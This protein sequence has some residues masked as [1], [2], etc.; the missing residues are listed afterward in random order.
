V[1]KKKAESSEPDNWKCVVAG[2]KKKIGADCSL[3]NL[4]EESSKLKQIEVI[5]LPLISL[6]RALGTFGFPL[7]RIVEIYGPESCGK[8]SLALYACLSAIKAFPDAP[9]VY[10]DLEHSLNP[11]WIKT[12]KVDP[13]KLWITQPNNGEEA[14]DTILS[15]VSSG[16][17]RLV[18]LDSVAAIATKDELEGSIE[19]SNMGR[20]GLLMG[21]F[22]KK[23]VPTLSKS[24]CTFMA[25]N[26]IRMKLGSMPGEERPG[27]RAL[28]YYASQIMRCRKVSDIVLPH[29][30]DVGGIW[31]EINVKKNKVAQPF[32]TGEAPL[33]F[34][35]GFSENAS[36][37]KTAV[38]ENIIDLKG[39]WYNYKG[40]ALGQGLWKAAENLDQNIF[41]EIY[42]KLKAL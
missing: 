15:V 41:V 35:S 38:L 18:V 16:Y 32:R 31:I 14:V 1:A 20:V 24:N 7:G 17:P 11:E 8:T 6:G 5:P 21:K 4:G 22:M 19:K 28:R 42:E 23:L 36:L 10:V 29:E 33:L 26:Q 27:G 39:S 3:F 25:I 37:I 40:E 13:S 2:L 9:I 30:N 34:K 12:L